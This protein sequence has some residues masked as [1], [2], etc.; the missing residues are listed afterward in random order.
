MVEHFKSIEAH[1]HAS[2]GYWYNKVVKML[3]V[4]HSSIEP[5]L[6]HRLTRRDPTSFT[7][8]NPPQPAPSLL[9]LQ[10]SLHHV[11]PSL[12]RL[13]MLPKL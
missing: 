11:L 10:Y 7:K 3:V 1:F 4:E 6:N 12:L 9:P 8:H 13:P 2:S 5:I